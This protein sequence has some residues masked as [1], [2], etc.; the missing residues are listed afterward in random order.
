MA[1]PHGASRRAQRFMPSHCAHVHECG[2]CQDA[3]PIIVPAPTRT[4]SS[5]QAANRSPAISGFPEAEDDP[6]RPTTTRRRS[7]SHQDERLVGSRQ[8]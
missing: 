3:S 8:N 1:A 4:K 5:A 7:A 2:D 6:A